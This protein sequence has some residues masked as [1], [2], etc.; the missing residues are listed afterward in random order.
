[1]AARSAPSLPTHPLTH[2]SHHNPT[3]PTPPPQGWAR[4][5]VLIVDDRLAKLYARSARVRKELPD[6]H[7]HLRTAVGVARG[8]QVCIAEGDDRVGWGGWV[9]RHHDRAT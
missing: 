6:Y 7:E 5:E 9:Q 3:T 4:C 2:V 1:M 8:M